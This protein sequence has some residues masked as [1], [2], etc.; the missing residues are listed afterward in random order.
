MPTPEQ[1][2]Q[3]LANLPEGYSLV[4]SFGRFAIMGQRDVKLERTSG[5]P[6]DIDTVPTTV[7][8]RPPTFPLGE[9]K[10]DAGMGQVFRPID[11]AHWGLFLP[12]EYDDSD[13]PIGTIDAELCQPVNIPIV[14]GPEHSVS[15]LPANIQDALMTIY[16]PYPKG[17]SH[18]RI[19][20]QWVANHAEPLPKEVWETF[21]AYRAQ[22]MARY[23]QTHTGV[24]QIY[25][26]A[27]RLFMRHAPE[28]V[29]SF[30][31]RSIGQAVRSIRGTTHGV[32]EE[33][34]GF[35]R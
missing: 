17:A 25:R 31:E 5:H 27:R 33:H 4:G 3:Q 20:R 10:I 13:S 16:G 21:D 32:A 18:Q 11:R 28:S 35:R 15:V 29:Q 34:R 1:L 8:P 6:R 22:S 23:K 26:G 9:F 19:F 12:R 30:A 7:D 2:T 24:E 14:W